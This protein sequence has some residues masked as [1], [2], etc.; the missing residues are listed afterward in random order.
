MPVESPLPTALIVMGVSGSGK[1]TI[2]ELLAAELGWPFRDGDDFHPPENVAK[3]HAGTPLTDE[4]RWPWL[5]AI[6]AWIEEARRRGGHVIVTCSALRRIYRDALRDG[7]GDVRFVYLEGTKDLIA[8]RLAKRKNH[9]MPPALL[10]SQ[11]ATLEPPGAD[12]APLAVSIGATPDEIAA[13]VLE[14]LA[15]FSRGSKSPR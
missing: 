2:A 8:S 3:M 9:F 14:K 6:A 13:M 7:H 12:E 15:G 4:D 10:D 1:S 5:A 11:F